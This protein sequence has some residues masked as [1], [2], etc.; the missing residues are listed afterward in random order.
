MSEFHHEEQERFLIRSSGF[1]IVNLEHV[2]NWV[3]ISASDN[4]KQN[5]KFDKFYIN[6]NVEKSFGLDILTDNS[7]EHVLSGLNN[8]KR[9]LVT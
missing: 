4:G 1:F 9:S 7:E 6:H 2:Y 5:E 8:S 3:G